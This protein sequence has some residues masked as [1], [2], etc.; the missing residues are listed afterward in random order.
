MWSH[1][2]QTEDMPSG[3]SLGEIH[4]L[5][6]LK[7][8]IT[9]FGNS[10]I[11]YVPETRQL[12]IKD[13]GEQGDGWFCELAPKKSMPLRIPGLR[14]KSKGDGWRSKPETEK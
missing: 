6:I 5:I 10:P 1:L 4:H 11:S 8:T 12:K 14:L 7:I 13:M 2:R 9:D 3:E